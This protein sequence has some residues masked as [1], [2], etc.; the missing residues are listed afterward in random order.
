MRRFTVSTCEQR[1]EEW[2]RLR[3]GLLTGSAAADMLATIKTGEAAA[4]RDLRLRLV[5]ERLTQRPQEDTYVNAAMQ[6]GIDTEPLARA[7][8]EAVTGEIVQTCG[9]VKL[10]DLAMGCSPDGYLGDFDT[11]LSIKCPKSATHLGYLQAGRFPVAYEPQLL[12]EML[13]T[14]ASA[15]EFLSFDPRFPEHMQR[16]RVTVKRESVESA[17]QDYAL[18]A[19]AFLK[20]IDEQVAQLERLTA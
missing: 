6:W 5:T 9:F 8:Y 18:K 12:H 3:A 13:V 1:S 14:G 7:A 20:E 16:F 17:I 4:R 11:L 2:F 15:Y 10:T 19:A